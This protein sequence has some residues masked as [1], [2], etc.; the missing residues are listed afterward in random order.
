LSWIAL[1]RARAIS[2]LANRYALINN[3]SVTIENPRSLTFRLQLI[4]F[5]PIEQELSAHR[6]GT[7]LLQVPNAYSAICMPLTYSS[8][9]LK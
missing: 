7:W 3:L 9:S 4:H 5:R 2:S 6:S 1:P 8:L